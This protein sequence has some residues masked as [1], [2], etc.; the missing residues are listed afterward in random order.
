MVCC[1]SNRLFCVSPTLVVLSLFVV[2]GAC[3]HQPAEPPPETDAPAAGEVEP[4]PEFLPSEQWGVKI[5]P[6][7]GTPTRD[8]VLNSGAAGTPEIVTADAF[9]DNVHGAYQA[10]DKLPF[11]AVGERF[12]TSDWQ[13]SGKVMRTLVAR[14]CERPP[15]EVWLGEDVMSYPRILIVWRGETE[16]RVMVLAENNDNTSMSWRV[17]D[18]AYDVQKSGLKSLKQDPARTPEKVLALATFL[19]N[20]ES[21]YP[22]IEA[23]RLQP[24]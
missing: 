16:T 10:I 12:R 21:V 18:K 14:A 1:K 22:H 8:E 9:L 15:S 23:Y 17:E 3:A 11:A 4:Q 13:V 7:P 20:T 24:H 6:L 2:L 19:E 5:V